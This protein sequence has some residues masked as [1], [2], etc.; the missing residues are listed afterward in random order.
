MFLLPWDAVLLL[1]LFLF[2]GKHPSKYTD[3]KYKRT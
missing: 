1:L 3:I 2:S